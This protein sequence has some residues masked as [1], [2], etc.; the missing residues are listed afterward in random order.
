[1]HPDPNRP[2]KVFKCENCGKVM[3]GKDALYKHQNLEKEKDT[4]Y[5][6][7]ICGKVGRYGKLGLI[8]HKRA[9]HSKKDKPC[10]YCGRLF[11]ENS[12][13]KNHIEQVHTKPLQCNICPKGYRTKA[14]LENHVNSQHLG[15]F[16]DRYLY[17]DWHCFDLLQFC[18]MSLKY[19]ELNLPCN[20]AHD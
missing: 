7:E 8:R 16:D 18:L 19:E 5:T 20:F 2:P 6:C 15:I 10:Q 4:E 1:M 17:H 9:A 11:S 14:Q 3:N 12:R 13:V